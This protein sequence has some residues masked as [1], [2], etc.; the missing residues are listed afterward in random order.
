[1][2]ANIIWVVISYFI[3]NVSS[4][5]LIG[6]VTA[7]IDIR[8]HGSGNAGTTNVLR[9]LGKKAAAATLVCDV[10]KGVIAVLI[11]RFFG[12]ETLAMICGLAAI[13]G[14]IWPALFG[15]RGGKGI[16]TGIGVIFATVPIPAFVCLGIGVVLIVITRFVSLGSICGAVL[17]PI[18]I[19]FYNETYFIWALCMAVIVIYTHRSNIKRLLNGNESK[20]SFNK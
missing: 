18:V 13:L 1:M 12:N 7:G 5:I 15:F 16:A 9:T 2:I 17:L 3:G 14:H 20:I 6:K 4:A 11:G 10:L 19:Y 8:D